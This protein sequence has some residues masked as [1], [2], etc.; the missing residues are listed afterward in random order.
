M[1]TSAASVPT[2]CASLCQP[3]HLAYDGTSFLQVV[4]CYQLHFSS[5]GK[6]DALCPPHT[7]TA[8]AEGQT[9][10]ECLSPLLLAS[11]TARHCGRDGHLLS[12]RLDW[13]GASG[14]SASCCSFLLAWAVWSVVLLRCLCCSHSYWRFLGKKTNNKFSHGGTAKLNF[15]FNKHEM[16]LWSRCYAVKSNCSAFSRAPT[17]F[18]FKKSNVC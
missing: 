12:A 11:A 16:Q 4:L 15:A 18:C 1:S 2:V 3:I 9:P 10:A 14:R 6:K 5:P 17:H 7:H 13:K 8:A